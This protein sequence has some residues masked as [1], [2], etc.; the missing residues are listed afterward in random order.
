VPSQAAAFASISPASIGRASTM[1]NTARQV[2]GALGVA[3]LTTV[4]SAVGITHVA[5]G[6]VAPNLAAFHWAF[7]V[8]ALI[9]MV[10]VW[11][12]LQIDDRDAASTMK[13]RGGAAVKGEDQLVRAS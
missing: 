1:F 13:P 10:A 12:A 7:G 2:G 11:F 8:A 6:R 9:A 4:I 5:D 3:A